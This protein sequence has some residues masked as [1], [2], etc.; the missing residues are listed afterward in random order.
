V[1]YVPHRDAIVDVRALGGARQAAAEIA[2][3]AYDSEA[4]AAKHAWRDRPETWSDGFKR[5]QAQ[6]WRDGVGPFAKCDLPAGLSD[7]H[8]RRQCRICKEVAD[9]RAEWRA[10]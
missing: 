5:L 7:P 6:T 3:L 9:W 4:Y 1:D 2:R 10:E 8:V